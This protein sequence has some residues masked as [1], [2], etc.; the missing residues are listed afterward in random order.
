MYVDKINIIM[1]LSS[2]ALSFGKII[3]RISRN[4]VHTT[5][6]PVGGVANNSF[7]SPLYGR[8]RSDIDCGTVIEDAFPSP[9]VVNSWSELPE[10]NLYKITS[11]FFVCRWQ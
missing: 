4:F 7:M 6:S 8:M 2:S 1:V 5:E 11:S 10:I 9:C 3:K